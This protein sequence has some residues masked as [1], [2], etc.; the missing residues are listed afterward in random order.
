MTS[1]NV[2]VIAEHIRDHLGK[3]YK[4]TV[5]GPTK[6]V[7]RDAEGKLLDLNMEFVY[8][9]GDDYEAKVEMDAGDL[10]ALLVEHEEEVKAKVVVPMVEAHNVVRGIR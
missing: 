4:L 6:G 7:F 2:K 8:R 5:T 3:D 9:P 1:D 10:H